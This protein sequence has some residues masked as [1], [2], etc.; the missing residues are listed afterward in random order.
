MGHM[1]RTHSTPGPAG[2]ILATT[3]T[4]AI[5]VAA[6][7]GVPVSSQYQWVTWVISGA[8][9]LVSGAALAI[10]IW[11]QVSNP[12]TRER[13]MKTPYNVYFRRDDSGQGPSELTV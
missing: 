1:L 5:L 2:P 3:A 6:A 9:L 11:K 4:V 7:L 12:A 13:Q 10:L 8:A